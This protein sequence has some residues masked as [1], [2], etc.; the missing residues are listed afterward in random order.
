LADREAL[1]ELDVVGPVIADAV[2]SFFDDEAQQRHLSGLIDSGLQFVGDVESK[3]QGTALLGKK[4]V[5]SG[6]FSI[7]R[8]EVKRLVE[9]QGGKLAGTVSGST[10]YLIAGEKMGPSKREKAERLGVRILSEVEFMEMM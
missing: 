4:C 2:L 10:D 7:P 9:Q 1:L 5:V 3:P 8:D 6:V